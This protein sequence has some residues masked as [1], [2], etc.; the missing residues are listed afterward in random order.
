MKNNQPT[1]VLDVD[2]VLLDFIP[3]WLSYAERLL[4][5]KVNLRIQTAFQL[6]QKFDVSLAEADAVWDFFHRDGGWLTLPPI[7]GAVE[8]VNELKK[9]CK[10]VAVTAIDPKNL[11]EREQNLHEHGMA[12]PVIAVGMRACKREVLH[13]IKPSLF[14]D[15]MVHN[16]KAAPPETVKIWLNTGL[17]Q[18]VP[19][20]TVVSEQYP[21]LAG[22]LHQNPMWA[23]QIGL[24]G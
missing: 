23:A 22:W 9:H 17:E 2:G 1:V 4:E 13:R 7:P 12:M 19:W 10:V 18:E 20:G 16:L 14:I 24:T 15:D 5:R 11:V 6:H 21:D 3:A 8:V